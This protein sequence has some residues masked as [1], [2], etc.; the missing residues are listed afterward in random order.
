[1]KHSAARQSERYSAEQRS[2]VR[3]LVFALV[4]TVPLVIIT[5]G[6]GRGWFGLSS[7]KHSRLRI[8]D[9]MLIPGFDVNTLIQILLTTPV[10]FV[11]G[12][13]FYQSA[14]VD[15]RRRCLGMNFLIAAGTTAAY[16]YSCISVI[17]GLASGTPNGDMLFFDTSAMLIS[18]ILLGKMMEK[19]ARHRASN[20]VGKL[21]VLR[22]ATAVVMTAWPNMQK[23]AIDV[24]MSELRAGDVVKVLRGTAVPSDGVV[25]QGTATVDES[26][27]T[28]ESMPVNKV[29]R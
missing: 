1:V 7:S 14:W 18:F 23:E 8:L 10:Q 16:L 15:V 11:S 27:L 29:R 26:M 6:L 12:W 25:V 2:A 9:H 4:F 21:M 5:M 17:L 24:A 28:G 13:V 20:A 22:P 3:R 19:I